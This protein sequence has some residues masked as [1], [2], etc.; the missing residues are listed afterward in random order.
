M[1][2]RM[3]ERVVGYRRNAAAERH[4]MTAIAEDPTPGR[5]AAEVAEGLGDE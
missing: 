5:Q 3:R 1:A 2:Y 4:R